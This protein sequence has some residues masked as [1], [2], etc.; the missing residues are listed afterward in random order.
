MWKRISR[1]KGA[2]HDQADPHDR[3]R[4]QRAG[5]ARGTSVLAGPRPP[6]RA[7][8]V[9]ARFVDARGR[10]AAAA[11]SCGITSTSIPSF[12]SLRRS[13]APTSPS[14]TRR[15]RFVTV[16]SSITMTRAPRARATAASFFAGAPRRSHLTVCGDAVGPQAPDRPL[17]PTPA[18]GQLGVRREQPGM[19]EAERRAVDLRDRDDRDRV[20]PGEGGRT[21][22]RPRREVLASVR[23]EHHRAARSAGRRNGGD[24]TASASVWARGKPVAHAFYGGLPTGSDGGVRRAE[25]PSSSI[26]HQ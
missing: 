11:S 3:R 16:V 20:L 9:A 2:L 15:S 8:A 23:G 19:R 6:A 17:H 13:S 24:G 4:S 26:R 1:S 21:S 12:R 7:E 18:L 25:V 10:Q 22:D 5:R 14:I